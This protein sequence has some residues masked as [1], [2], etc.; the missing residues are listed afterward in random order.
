MIN[1]PFMISLLISLIHIDLIILNI[2]KGPKVLNKLFSMIRN[3][4]IRI[5]KNLISIKR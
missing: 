1:P 3:K 2:E 4:P 5:I